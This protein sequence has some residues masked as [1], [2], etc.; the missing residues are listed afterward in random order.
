M[1][2]REKWPDLLKAYFSIEL[3]PDQYRTWCEELNGETDAKVCEAIRWASKHWKR[4]D[5]VQ[6]NMTTL[7]AWLYKSQNGGNQEQK[8]QAAIEFQRKVDAQIAE[9]CKAIDEADKKPEIVA[10]IESG[11]E[12]LIARL[13]QYA[14]TARRFDYYAFKRGAECIIKPSKALTA[15]KVAADAAIAKMGGG[16]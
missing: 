10:A 11:G 13:A 5:F 3:T 1:K 8:V 15:F 16:K 9:K 7:Q 14:L 12:H 2:Q 4:P 6:I